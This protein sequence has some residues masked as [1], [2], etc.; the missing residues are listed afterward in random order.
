MKALR[1]IKE[2]K[3]NVE[4]QE[5]PVPKIKDNE[6]L[7]KVWAASR[8]SSYGRAYFDRI[9]HRKGSSVAIIALARRLSKIAYIGIYQVYY[10]SRI[11]SI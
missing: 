4:I 1:K 6:V 5:V 3:G 7:M 11:C 9:K 10:F 2:G 8:S